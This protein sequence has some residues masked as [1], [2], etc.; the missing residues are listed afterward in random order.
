MLNFR[1]D[2]HIAKRRAEEAVSQSVIVE[3]GFPQ[4]SFEEAMGWRGTSS[5]GT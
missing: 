2:A 3:T 4:H 5:L 1:S